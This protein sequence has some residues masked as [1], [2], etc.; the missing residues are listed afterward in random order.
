[1]SQGGV[2]ERIGFLRRR[3]AAI[4]AR[5]GV[6]RGVREGARDSIDALFSPGR[7]GLSEL[8]PA[9]PPDAPGAGAFALALALRA[10]AARGGGALVWI[11]EDFSA[12]EFGLP[13][14]RGLAAAGMDLS[15]FAL[16]R[17]RRPRETLWAMEEALRSEAC[18]AVVA[19]SFLPARLYDLSASRRLLL[20]ARRG[21]GLGLVVAQGAEATRFS[22]AAELRLEIAA[23]PVPPSRPRPALSP[24]A[25]FAW[26]LRVTKARAG[27]LG[28]TGEIDPGQW[29]DLAFD[30]ERVVFRHAFPER[31]PAPSCDRP[32][33]AAARR[34]RA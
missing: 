28:E 12:G 31:L 8:L 5:D 3:I 13:Y 21:G 29:R 32:A 30:P 33:A 14:G 15:R 10:Q 9:R 6:A 26:R 16:I 24:A 20:A 2:S 27:L 18:A 11:V 4:E 1:M 25:P 23:A 7:A 19:E 34:R 17:V 22:S